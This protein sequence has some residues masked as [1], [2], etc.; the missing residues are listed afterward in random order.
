MTTTS[1]NRLPSHRSRRII[2]AKGESIKRGR[3]SVWAY[4]LPGILTAM[5]VPGTHTSE[6]KARAALKL[7]TGSVPRGTKLWRKN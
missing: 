1:P 2:L 7:S 5:E 4:R 3:P 6:S